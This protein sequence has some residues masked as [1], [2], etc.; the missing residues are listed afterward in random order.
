MELEADLLA[1]SQIALFQEIFVEIE[2]LV[3][4]VIFGSDLILVKILD[5]EL[6]FFWKLVNFLETNPKLIEH[7]LLLRVEYDL[8]IWQV[9][10]KIGPLLK[11]E[12]QQFNILILQFQVFGQQQCNNKR[13]HHWEVQLQLGRFREDLIQVNYITWKVICKFALFT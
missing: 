10:K 9:V 5:P 4:L 12:S 1:H 7:W 13:R 3:D 8:D 6:R 11:T 2:N